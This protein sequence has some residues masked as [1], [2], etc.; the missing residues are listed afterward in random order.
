[1]PDTGFFAGQG[2]QAQYQPSQQAGPSVQ[3]LMSG[4]MPQLARVIPVESL[5]ACLDSLYPDQPRSPAAGS[6]MAALC[7]FALCLLYGF[8]GRLF[9]KQNAIV[10][11]ALCR[12]ASGL[13]FRLINAT[14]VSSVIVR[15]PG[16]PVKKRG[17]LRS[18]FLLFLLPVLLSGIWY[19]VCSEIVNKI[20]LP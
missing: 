14:P 19:L 11:D 13:L 16:L 15:K 18:P 3:G 6:A 17:L 5:P 4:L 9:G 12:S 10:A 7:L 2:R 20:P 8:R 1:M